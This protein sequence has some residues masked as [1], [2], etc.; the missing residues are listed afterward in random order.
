MESVSFH[1]IFQ[2]HAWQ[3]AANIP[4][5]AGTTSC[6][7]SKPESQPAISKLTL[8]SLAFQ[9]QKLWQVVDETHHSK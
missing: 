4:T 6:G 9:I 5:L 7:R 1:Y 8:V 3:G 2:T